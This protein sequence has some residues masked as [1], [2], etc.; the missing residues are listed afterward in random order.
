MKGET[1][2]PVRLQRKRS[3]GPLGPP[4]TRGVRSLRRLPPPPFGAG[5]YQNVPSTG[6]KVG[7]A[8]GRMRPGWREAR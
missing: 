3:G 6:H 2:E 8:N 7:R 5:T 4:T 1:T